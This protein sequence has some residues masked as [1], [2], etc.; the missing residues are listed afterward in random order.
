MLKYIYNLEPFFEDCY[1]ELGVREYSRIMNMTPPTASKLLKQY[2]SEGFLKSRSERKYLLFSANRQSKIMK[3]FSRI[4]WSSKF[5]K[6]IE[7]LNSFSPKAIVLFGSLSKLETKKKSD[8]DILVL[9]FSNKKINLEKFEKEL[10]R[11][12]QIF[13]YDSLDKINKELKLNVINGYL[14][15]GYIS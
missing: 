10:K 2:V 7:Y 12:I 9:G 15:G 11:E 3:D 13:Q 1:V 5:I 8:V 4:Y 6:L 14:L